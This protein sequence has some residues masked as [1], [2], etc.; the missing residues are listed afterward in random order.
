VR[1][2]VAER[3]KRSGVIYAGSR[4][5]VDKL[6]Q[7][8]VADGV[9]ALPYHAGLDKDL[10]AARLEQFLE[11]ETAVMV[12][13]IAFGMG[14]DKPDIRYVIHADPPASIEAYWQEIGLPGAMVRRQRGSPSIPSPTSPGRCGV[15]TCGT[16]T[17]L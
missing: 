13:T 15:S 4:D 2:L 9:P 16:S 3:P 12:A 11:A 1:E 14:V 8:L 10:R 6:S 17:A 7:K 5:G